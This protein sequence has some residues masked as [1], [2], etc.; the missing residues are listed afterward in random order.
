M[1]AG[2]LSAPNL[3]R[4][5]CHT[6]EQLHVCVCVCVCVR[7]LW[8]QSYTPAFMFAPAFS[9]ISTHLYISFALS[10]ITYHSPLSFC[11]HFCSV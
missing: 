8:N 2:G 11:S 6:A 4:P 7:A 1:Q 9:C 5:A 3:V 10:N